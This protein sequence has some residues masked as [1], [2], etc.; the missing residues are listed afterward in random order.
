MKLTGEPRVRSMGATVA[1]G[2]GS[3]EPV[4]LASLCDDS[5]TWTLAP[6]PAPAPSAEG[7]TQGADCSAPTPQLSFVETGIITAPDPVSDRVCL[8]LGNG[9]GVWST[10]LTVS[11]I[12]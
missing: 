8:L 4:A 6:S 11:S 3:G 2:G 5:Q 12:P 7:Q 10:T 9:E 1:R